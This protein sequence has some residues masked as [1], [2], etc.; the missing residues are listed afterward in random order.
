MKR[1][2][3]LFL[4]LTLAVL[5][6]WLIGRTISRSAIHIP[7]SPLIANVFEAV[8][9]IGQVAATFGG[10]LALW[11]GGWI[12]WRCW[13]RNRARLFSL[14]WVAVLGLSLGF[15]FIPGTGWVT[16]GYCLLLITLITFT[17]G[18]LWQNET[19]GDK[20]LAVLLPLGVLLI[21]A[22]YQLAPALSEGLQWS[23][24]PHLMGTLFNMGEL[25]AVLC[26]LAWWWAYGR[27][28]SR[29]TWIAAG[30]LALAFVSMR[31]ASPSMTG[32]L[33]IWST[34]LTLYLPWPIYAVSLWFA[35]VTIIVLLRR[36]ELFGW[37][38]LLLAVSG[39]APQLST[40]MLSGL[41]ALWLM[42]QAANSTLFQPVTRHDSR[43]RSVSRS[44]SYLR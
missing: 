27:G 34:G 30:F 26:P 12:A 42:A 32:T 19:R 44:P 4:W 37:A 23:A 24:P 7:K 5:A 14:V 21:T 38:I 25:L 16:V 10:L 22:L 17:A 20:R 40:Q 15:L 13:Q 28:A 1:F 2:P 6:D 3:P 29:K 36:G 35:A 8:N 41:V 9:L 33:A 43:L 31:L 18:Q 11:A 39:Y